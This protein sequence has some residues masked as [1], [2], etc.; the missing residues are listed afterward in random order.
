MLL[1]ET[2]AG[3]TKVTLNRPERRNALSSALLTEL[4]ATLERLADDVL[5]RVVVLASSGPVFSSGHDLGEMVGRSES[6]YQELFSRCSAV[7]QQLRKLPQP[8][9]AR[10]QGLATAAGCQLVAAC[11]LAVAANEAKFATPGV[12]IGLFCSTPMVPLVRAIPAKAAMEMLMTGVPIPAQ[13]A[14]ELGLVN[15]VVAADELDTVIKQMT[16]A[17][18]ASSPMTIRLGKRAFYDQLHL[19]EPSAYV[20]A[21]QVM[22]DNAMKHDAQEGISAFLQKRPAQWTGE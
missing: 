17:I 10:V 21:T 9:L 19:D 7:M 11:D 8:V 15:R 18:V 6:E 2:N 12:K 22:T 3:V 5:T 20:R 4:G 1:V 14:L 13:R 16:D